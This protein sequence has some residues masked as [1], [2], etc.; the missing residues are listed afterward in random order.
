M[1]MSQ[2]TFHVRRQGLVHQRNDL[3]AIAVLGEDAQGDEV[4]HQ[5]GVVPVGQVD[6]GRHHGV[7]VP[8][9]DG[10]HQAEVD[11]RDPG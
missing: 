2:L 8:L 6:D 11:Q 4:I 5:V 7:H 10:R 1:C 3:D 9:L